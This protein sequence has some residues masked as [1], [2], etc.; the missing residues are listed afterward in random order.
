MERIEREK[1][2]FSRQDEFS[3]LISNQELQIILQNL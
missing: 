1:K 2:G 3:Y